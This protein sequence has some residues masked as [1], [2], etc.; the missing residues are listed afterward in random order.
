MRP[1][2]LVLLALALGC[3]LI[4]SIGISQV[5]DNQNKPARVETAPIYVAQQNINVNDPITDAMVVLEEWPKDK[6]PPG[7][8]VKW[9]DIEDRRPRTNIYQGEPLL[10]S[11]LLAKGQISDPTQGVPDGMRLKTMSVDATKSAAGLLSPGDRVD[12]QIFVARNEQQGIDK[13]FTKIFLQNIRVYAVDQTIDRSM[14]GNEARNVAKTVSLI[15]TPAQANRITLAEN[16]GTITLIP[17]NPDDEAEVDDYEQDIESLLNPSS[18]NSRSRESLTKADRPEDE[19][20]GPGAMESLKAFMEAAMAQNSARQA[21]PGLVP[22]KPFQ[23]TIIYPDEV[24]RLQ[25]SDGQLVVPMAPGQGAGAP[26]VSSGTHEPAA[27][28]GA[29]GDGGTLQL[30]PDFPIDLQVK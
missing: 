22:G 4:A 29:D 11:K 20:S 5:L 9:E 6:V 14:D 15:V 7:A 30:P 19:Q 3:G 1:K 13:P 16:L 25:F 17:R 26:F 27:P 21:A 28:Q 18:A 23:M 10:N 24:E 12:V 2:S 8:I